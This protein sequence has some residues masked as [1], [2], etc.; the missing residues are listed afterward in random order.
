MSLEMPVNLIIKDRS[1]DNCEDNSTPG[2]DSDSILDAYDPW[3]YWEP[4]C[5]D[6]IAILVVGRLPANR[7]LEHAFVDY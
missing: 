1:I 6:V 3:V 2:R 5:V 4:Y 7:F